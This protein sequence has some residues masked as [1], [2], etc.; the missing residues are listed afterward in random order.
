M[1]SPLGR[2]LG[3]GAAGDGT[4]HW[5]WQRVSAAALVPLGLW[6][7][8]AVARIAGAEHVEVVA[9]ISSPVTTVLLVLFILVSI[10]HAQLG[11]QVVVED[12]VHG[13]AVRIASLVL[14]KFAAAL[15][16]V[17][18]VLAVLRIAVTG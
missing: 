6:F 16:A 7:L 11:V 18:G 2:A 1:R 17:A 12:Y 14:V 15:L 3:L 9:W 4:L 10:Y 13:E 8:F 5:W